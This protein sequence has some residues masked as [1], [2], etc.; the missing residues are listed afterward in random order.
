MLEL[1]AI[2]S[3]LI[4]LYVYSG[5]L[6][7]LKAIQ[8]L[9]PHHHKA[10][11]NISFRKVTVLL[12]VHNEEVEI[13]KRIDNI[14]EQDY[15]PEMLDVLVAS[16]GSTDAT[17]RIVSEIADSRVRLFVSEVGQ[18]KTAT[19][20]AAIKLAIGDVVI[21]TDAGSRF[22]VDFTRRIASAFCDESVG[23]ADGHL[24]FVANDSN[25]IARSQGYYW[26]YELALRE[27]ESRL[28]ILAVASGACLA[29][30][31]ELLKEMETSVGEDC[32]VP[33]DVVLQG[34]QVV[35]VPE[36]IA[37][38][39]ME[40]DADGEFHARVRMTLRNWQGTWS[41]SA[42]LNPMKYPGVAFALWSH[43]LLRWLSPYFL[44]ASTICVIAGAAVG[45]KIM[46]AALGL[47]AVFYGSALVG[48]ASERYH[49]GIPFVATVYSFLLAN[50]GF[51]VG[52]S[53]AL[54]GKKI[55]KYR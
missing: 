27:A 51:L 32:I 43:K 13:R 15:S 28:G 3:A 20:N 53:K 34:R 11:V 2:C 48:W 25:Q 36:A 49:W 33:L 24:L 35:H 9:T 45:G 6:Y 14:L 41:R 30:R 29:V 7:V 23:A 1:I 12:T 21:F 39:A 46:M 4:L 17:N 47:L 54:L 19:Q 38:D 44:I 5:Y 42:L 55:Y 22:E 52:V 8:V 18:G 16:D 40:N 10:D 26:R 50:A 37:Y 31:R